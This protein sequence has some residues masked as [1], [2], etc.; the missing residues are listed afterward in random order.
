MRELSIFVD[1]SGDFGPYSFYSPYYL[2]ALVLHEQEHSI[3]AAVDELNRKIIERGF[4]I[5]A[6][7][8][9][10]II[11]NEGFYENYTPEDRKR[12]FNDLLFFT[13]AIDLQYHI[14]SVDKKQFL[15]RRRLVDRLSKQL[16]EFVRENFEYISGFNNIIVY[17]DYGQSEITTILTS[18]FNS[19]FVNV[20]FRHVQPH[21]YKLFQVADM[22]C[23]LELSKLKFDNNTQSVSEENFYGSRRQFKDFYYKTI[24]KKKI[25]QK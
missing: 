14:V 1:E 9:E 3:D 13:K 12:L 25:R 18:V 6:I 21:Q 23:T 7:H 22:I 20:D 19:F 15:G 24:Q 8:S 10:P 17:Y 5:H 16:A 11:R 4:P 2:F